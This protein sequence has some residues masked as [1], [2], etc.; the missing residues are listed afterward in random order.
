MI[1]ENYRL[2]LLSHPNIFETRE[3]AI[4]YITDN[5]R[6]KALWSEPA[7]FF[8][9]TAREPKMIVAVGATTDPTKPRL[10]LIDDEEIRERMTE[11]AEES[12]ASKEEADKAI[13]DLMSAI[14]ALGLTY[15]DNKLTNRVSY[16]P[17]THD[18]L[19]GHAETVCDAIATISQYVQEKF[20][21]NELSVEETNSTLLT[22]TPSNNGTK[23]TSDIKVSTNGDDDSVDFNDNIIGVKTDG[24]YAAVNLEYDP[25][26]QQLIFTTSGINQAG[27]FKNDARRTVI[28]LADNLVFTGISTETANTTVTKLEHAGWNVSSDVKLSNNHSIIVYD[29][30]IAANVDFEVD[31]TT[32]TITF[33]VGN[34]EKEYKLPGVNIIDHIEYDG[35]NREIKIYVHGQ[36]DPLIIPIE[37]IIETW[38]VDNPTSSPVVLHREEHTGNPDSVYA[39]LKLRSDDNLLNI[40]STTGNLYVSE[41]TING[42]ISVVS[43]SLGNLEDVVDGLSASVA[44]ETDRATDAETEL[45]SSITDLTATVLQ[46]KEDIETL[47]TEVSGKV[48]QVVIEKNNDLQYFL[49]V[50]GVTTGT[51]D[52]PEDKFLKSVT[53]NPQTKYLTFVFKTTEGDV[54][55]NI[56]ISDLVD[57]YTAGD[58]L[59][60]SNN[61]FSVVVNE[62]TENYLKLTGEGLKIEGVDQALAGKADSSDVYTKADS[63]AKF[64]YSTSAS[65]TV[66]SSILNG[67]ITS[68]V[69]LNDGNNIITVGNNGLNVEVDLTFDPVKNWI[70]LSR[71]NNLPTTVIDL[72]PMIAES[73]SSINN[74][75]YD[76]VNK[77]LVIE[78]VK[79][80]GGVDTVE[81]DVSVDAVNVSNT[82]GNPIQLSISTVNNESV[83]SATLGI[84]DNEHNALRNN[85]GALFVSDQAESYQAHW[86]TDDNDIT[87]QTAIN[88]LKSTTDALSSEI[89]E[90]SGDITTLVQEMEDLKDENESLRQ[91]VAALESIIGD[92]NTAGTV[93]ARLKEIENVTNNLLDF[94]D[95]DGDGQPDGF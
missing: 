69:K 92:E 5:F 21:E 68:N 85:S 51:I 67:V 79:T 66:E 30:G 38:N 27:K 22:L 58:G 17:D 15:D 29:G 62:D 37:N 25:Y 13:E 77:K 23:L 48:S 20:N 2:Q 31:L 39:T 53:Y 36:T 50:D 90:Y 73:V 91:R 65:S 32:N 81:M 6:G 11:I 18:E 64:V 43:D 54:T 47:E 76:S 82:T 55:T 4:E 16:E 70:T 19:I 45:N 10:C 63:D 56:D 84:S 93:L 83:I 71:G 74:M 52:I 1:N 60:L 88:R 12:G 59:A 44:N 49:K 46:N 61:Q 33:K 24:I 14:D 7:L 78:Y 3:D 86:G 57:V 26:E 28:D 34:V 94:G 87:V 95:V 35:D 8:Y 40:D 41:A 80:G 75:Y 9:G 42:K 89:G 72:S